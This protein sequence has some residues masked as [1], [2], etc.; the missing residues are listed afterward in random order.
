MK[1]PSNAVSEDSKLL[2]RQMQQP[3]VGEAMFAPT[4]TAS[5]NAPTPSKVKDSHDE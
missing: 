2:Q 4:N 1:T 3:D 5:M